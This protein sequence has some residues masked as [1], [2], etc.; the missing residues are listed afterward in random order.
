TLRPPCAGLGET[1]FFRRS[2]FRTSLCGVESIV[3]PLYLFNSDLGSKL[4]TWLTPPHRK[5]QMTDLAFGGACGLPSG[6]AFRACSARA[7]PSR[8]SMA[9]SA[10]PV[11]PIPVSARKERRVTPG[12]QPDCRG[13]VAIIV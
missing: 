2:G 9:V 11:K 5:I 8:K 13:C 10:R 3:L 4:S 7:I 1:T 6:L 12:Q